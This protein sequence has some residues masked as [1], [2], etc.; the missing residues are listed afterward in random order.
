MALADWDARLLSPERALWMA[1]DWPLYATFEVAQLSQFEPEGGGDPQADQWQ[2][3]LR[4][5]KDNQS[6]A[7]LGD[8]TS[9][10]TSIGD[11]LS[12]VVRHMVT[13]H[14]QSLSG[15]SPDGGQ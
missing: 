9:F 8:A 6:V 12:A 13:A 11:L 5:R 15:G 14:D 10:T 4:C 1:G 7:M 3:N 2:I